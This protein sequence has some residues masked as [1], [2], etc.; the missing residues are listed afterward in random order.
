ML[1]LP[2]APRHVSGHEFILLPGS[3][4]F[5]LLCLVCRLLTSGLTALSVLS[6]WQDIPGKNMTSIMVRARSTD[7][8]TAAAVID[9]SNSSL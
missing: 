6:C 7:L 1:A 8:Q 5:C 4:S 3:L 2:W 9:S